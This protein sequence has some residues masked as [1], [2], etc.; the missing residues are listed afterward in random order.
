V[1]AMFTLCSEHVPAHRRGFYVT[2]VASYW[3]VVRMIR[4][5]VFP[6]TCPTIRVLC[7]FRDLSSR[8]G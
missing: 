5:F 6:S 1:P 2:L 7:C 8:Q 4:Y 3:M